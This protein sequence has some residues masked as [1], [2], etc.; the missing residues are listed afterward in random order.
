MKADRDAA[1]AS[2]TVPAAV[3]STL[4]MSLALEYKP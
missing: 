4:N 1:G 2:N 3:S